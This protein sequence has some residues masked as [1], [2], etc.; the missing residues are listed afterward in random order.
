M[1]VQT[2]GI[3][4]ANGGKLKSF[5]DCLICVPETETFLIQELTLPIYHALCAMLEFHFFN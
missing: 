4:G 1:G 2:V 5:C 3:S